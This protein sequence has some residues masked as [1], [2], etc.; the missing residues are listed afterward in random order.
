MI[1]D[2]LDGSDVIIRGLINRRWRERV[3]S[4]ERLEDAV[5]QL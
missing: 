4:G 5:L 1:L 2:N 3:K